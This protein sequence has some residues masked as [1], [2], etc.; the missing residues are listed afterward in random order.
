MSKRNL[1]IGIAAAA[2]VFAAA[3]FISANSSNSDSANAPVVVEV[4]AEPQKPPA[5]H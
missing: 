5:P 2:I 1:I 3:L 4:S